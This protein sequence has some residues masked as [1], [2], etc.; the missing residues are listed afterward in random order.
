[1]SLLSLL[2]WLPLFW[3]ISSIAD[4]NERGRAANE[5]GIGGID[6]GAVFKMMFIFVIHVPFLSETLRD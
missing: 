2:L 3:S 1:M 5:R 6:K 4:V